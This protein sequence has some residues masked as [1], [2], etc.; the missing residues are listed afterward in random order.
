MADGPLSGLRVIEVCSFVAGPLAGLLL[1]QQGADV[2]RVDP[3]GGAADIGR[4]PRAPDGTSIYWSGLNKHKR[5]VELDLRSERGRD[6]VR[7]L[8]GAPGREGGILLTNAVGA[9]WLD[10]GHLR[11]LREDVIK[12]HVQ[13]HPDGEPAVDYTVNAE[14]GFPLVTGPQEWAGP[15][16]HVLPAW[17]VV[18]GAMAAN[19]VL[20]AERRRL[21]DGNGDLVEVALADVALAMAGHLGYLAEAQAFDRDRPRAGNAVYGTYGTDFPTAD[22]RH[23]MVTAI[24]RRQW[25]GLLDATGLAG[26][27]DRIAEALGADFDEE[28]DRY[29]AREVI[30]G[31]LSPWFAARSTQQVAEAFGGRPVLWSPYRT[32]REFLAE[33][34]DQA[35]LDEIDQP[36]IGRHHAPRSPLRFTGHAPLPA[37]PAPALGAHTRS[38]LSELLGL[39]A[40]EWSQLVDDRVVR[41]EVRPD[42][43]AS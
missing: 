23:V 34:G 40:S 20:V 26:V 31:V 38:V 24:T 15:V 3:I 32:F 30:T 9:S 29:A 42:E 12:V 2:I 33:R 35:L 25:R 16:N 14:L 8:V 21:L 39:A 36:G 7:R 1:A 17:D 28:A 22:G 18:T 11:R 37:R 41:P 19:A 13:G 10:M 5:S 43:D 6:L 27:V 4:L